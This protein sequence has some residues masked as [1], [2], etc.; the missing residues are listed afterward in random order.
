VIKSTAILRV[1]RALNQGRTS[2]VESVRAAARAG[3]VTLVVK[4][5]R[6]GADLELWAGEKERAYFREVFGRELDFKLV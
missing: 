1:A 6:A 5:G 4:A 2:A 3:D